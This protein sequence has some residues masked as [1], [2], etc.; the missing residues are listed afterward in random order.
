MYYEWY[1]GDMSFLINQQVSYYS[2][3]A[4]QR[5]IPI[6]EEK[7]WR[8]VLYLVGSFYIEQGLETKTSQFVGEGEGRS[9]NLG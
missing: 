7:I 9:M 3:Q 6:L 1:G 2:C 8:C 5:R 4:V